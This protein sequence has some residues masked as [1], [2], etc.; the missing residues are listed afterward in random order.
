MLEDGSHKGQ[1][2]VLYLFKAFGVSGSKYFIVNINIDSDFN[3]DVI[4]HRSFLLGCKPVY[5]TFREANLVTG[6][7]LSPGAPTSSPAHVQAWCW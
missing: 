7:T 4:P 1:N 6:I 5:D 2:P 3:T